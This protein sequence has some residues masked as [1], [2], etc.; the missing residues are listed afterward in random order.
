[1]FDEGL[2]LQRL[3]EDIG[4]HVGG[5]LVD[6]VDFSAFDFAPKEMVFDVDM[7]GSGVVYSVF[8]HCD[9][10]LIVFIDYRGFHLLNL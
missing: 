10:A 4:D 7:F 1:M 3:G 8:R 2:L 6:E 5:G 9:A